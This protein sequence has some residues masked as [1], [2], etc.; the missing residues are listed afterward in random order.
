MKNLITNRKAYYEYHISETLS[1]GI[2]LN[3]SE[4]RPIKESKTSINEA[5]CYI[6]EGE[7]FIKGM[8]VAPHNGNIKNYTHDTN[9]DRKLLVKKIEI[10]RLQQK[11]GEKGMT[12]VP[13]SIVLNDKGLIKIIIGLAK[14]KNVRDKSVAIKLKDL[15]RDM[16]KNI[17][18]NFGE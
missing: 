12:I 3:G 13:V 2:Q 1:C 4:I 7:L 9:R 14:G 5:Y 10:E 18:N 11:V 17:K 6:S 15:D 16:K 8:Y